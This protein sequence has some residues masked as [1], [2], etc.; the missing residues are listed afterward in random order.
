MKG[1]I[2]SIYRNEVDFSMLVISKALS[3]APTDYPVPG[4]SFK[5]TYVYY[6]L[7]LNWRCAWLRV[8][9]LPLPELV[10]A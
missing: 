10:V 9:L 4:V 2:S 8:I 6:R 1:V 3:K 5:V 7:M